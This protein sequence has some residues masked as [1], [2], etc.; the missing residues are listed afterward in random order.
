[1]RLRY[2]ILK[3]VLLPILHKLCQLVDRLRA[4]RL[5]ILIFLHIPHLMMQF[6]YNAS[7]LFLIGLLILV[8]FD[9]ALL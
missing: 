5:Q 8:E 1:M 4:L 7:E 6:H 9:D 3:S 2:S